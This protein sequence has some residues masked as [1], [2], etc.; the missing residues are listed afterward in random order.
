M[1][2]DLTVTCALTA[3]FKL[4]F[5][6]TNWSKSEPECPETAARSA[7]WSLS[8][9]RHQD[10]WFYWNGKWAGR[11]ALRVTVDSLIDYCLGHTYS[12][13]PHVWPDR[14]RRLEGLILGPITCESVRF[15]GWAVPGKGQ[16]FTFSTQHSINVATWFFFL[17]GVLYFC[18][19]N[20]WCWIFDWLLMLYL[21]IH[22]LFLFIFLVFRLR[23]WQQ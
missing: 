5:G 9:H 6:E 22:L 3:L 20:F 15:P 19:P 13:Q 12:R 18:L 16:F 17:L 2:L 8:P 11:T 21:L 1:S 23:F 10:L 14:S 7:T 4:S